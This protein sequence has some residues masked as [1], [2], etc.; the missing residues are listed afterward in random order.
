MHGQRRLLPGSFHRQ[1]RIIARIQR[2]MCS[3]MA[4]LIAGAGSQKYA[5]LLLSAHKTETA[6]LRNHSLM[7]SFPSGPKTGCGNV[8]GT[9]LRKRW[10]NLVQPKCLSSLHRLHSRQ[11]SGA[12][13]HAPSDINQS[14]HKGHGFDVH[15]AAFHKL[16]VPVFRGQ[17]G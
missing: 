11:T 13:A 1:K 9:D 10:Q 12:P 7:A 15:A 8:A 5:T 4:P 3:S 6:G 14:P 17:K 16:R 2:N